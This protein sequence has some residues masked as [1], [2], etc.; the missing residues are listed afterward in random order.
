M[1]QD[2]P[3]FVQILGRY[4]ALIGIMALL[5]LLGG[6]VFAALNP[7]T[8][9]SQALVIFPASSC[10][11]G[12][13]CG[14]P[15]FEP[16]RSAYI[17][18]KLLQS[19]PSGVQLEPMEANGL[20]VSTTAGTAAQAEAA[21]NAAARTYLAYADSMSYPGEQVS[22]QVFEPATRATGTAPLI[23]LRD[24]LLLGAVLGALLG[25]IAALAGSGAT[26]DTLTAPPGYDIGEKKNRP[27]LEARYVP[28]TV[29]L[30]QTAPE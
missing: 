26:I 10:P 29:P 15:M 20:L 24:D 1:S 25:I 7:P 6:A 23:R 9:T 11:A 17:G 28:T 30:Q 18:A 2:L 27:S 8:F 22:A 16:A 13:I 21:T 12:A 14:G 19:L 4:R 5:G 3:R